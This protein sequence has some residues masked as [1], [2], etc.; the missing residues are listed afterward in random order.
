M[1]RNTPEWNEKQRKF[2]QSVATGD[3]LTMTQEAFDFRNKHNPYNLVK[4]KTVNRRVAVKAIYGSQVAVSY[5]DDHFVG[6]S[7]EWDEVE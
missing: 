6:L 7:L 1:E 4:A 3:V 2:A 5:V